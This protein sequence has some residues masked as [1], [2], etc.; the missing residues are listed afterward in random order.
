[1]GAVAADGP[2]AGAGTGAGAGAA[3][4]AEQKRDDD[5][6]QERHDDFACALQHGPCMYSQTAKHARPC[7][8]FLSYEH[9]MLICCRVTP[10]M[11]APGVKLG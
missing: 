3:L 1:M 2:G 7:G 5:F 11:L 4:A 9:Q 6:D 10:G 8:P